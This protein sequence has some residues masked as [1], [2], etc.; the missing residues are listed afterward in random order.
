MTTDIIS[1]YINVCLLAEKNMQETGTVSGAHWNAMRSI[2]KQKGLLD[3]AEQ[4]LDRARKLKE[5]ESSTH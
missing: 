5:Y 2:L 3:V 4:D 1:F